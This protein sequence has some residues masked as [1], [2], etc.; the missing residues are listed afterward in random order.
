[1]CTRAICTSSARSTLPAG[2]RVVATGNSTVSSTRPASTHMDGLHRLA[3]DGEHRAEP[4]GT[5]IVVQ[6]GHHRPRIGLERHQRRREAG[7]L[8]VA[9]GRGAAA[10][11]GVLHRVQRRPRAAAVGPAGPARRDP[12]TMRAAS[13]R[14]T[15]ARWR[16]AAPPRPRCARPRPGRDPARG[17][18]SRR[19]RRTGRTAARPTR[20]A[21]SCCAAWR[22]RHGRRQGRAPGRRSWPNRS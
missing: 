1:M 17:R 7:Q 4:A 2:S 8:D 15:G 12:P 16:Q 21:S 11:Q 9:V 19:H 10:D 6:V 3:G 20:A 22:P 5:G 14:R 18:H 13:P